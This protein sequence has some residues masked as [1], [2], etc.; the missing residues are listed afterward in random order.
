MTDARI[1]VSTAPPG[2]AHDLARRLVEERLAACVNVLPGVRSVYRW[3]GGIQDDPETVLWIKTTA[4]RL[5]AL[6]ERVRA[7]HPY[8]VPE[9]LV[10]TPSS[11]TADYLAWIRESCM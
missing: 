11:G 1:V 4:E 2:V 5:P 3:K 7:L 9:V 6:E 10:L 8:E